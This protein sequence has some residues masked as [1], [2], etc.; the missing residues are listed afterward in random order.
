M[1]DVPTPQQVSGDDHPFIS[2]E[3]RRHRKKGVRN[4][5]D[6]MS[7]GFLTPFFSPRRGR[8]R[9]KPFRR[10]DPNSTLDHLQRA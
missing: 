2:Q 7:L 5:K 3:D 1:R 6:R 9:S 4:P 10:R 8:P